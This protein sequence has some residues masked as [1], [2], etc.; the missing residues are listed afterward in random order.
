M[1]L[2][3]QF[4]VFE[5]YFLPLTFK[6]TLTLLITFS[7]FDLMITVYFLDFLTLNAFFL[8]VNLLVSLMI[9]MVAVA[10]DAL[11]ASSPAKMTVTFKDSVFVAFNV[12]LQ[13][14]D[15]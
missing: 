6:V 5:A 15:R 14:P 3:L 1:N 13:Q 8:A 9:L 10:P 7:D 4:L 11:Y 2:A 12:M